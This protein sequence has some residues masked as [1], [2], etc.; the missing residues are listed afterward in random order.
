MLKPKV[1]EMVLTSSPL[2]RLR[3]VVLPALS[4]PLCVGATLF[5]FCFSRVHQ[6]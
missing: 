5:V 3:M 4:R 2:M 6:T 1:G